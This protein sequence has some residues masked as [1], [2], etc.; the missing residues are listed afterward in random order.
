MTGAGEPCRASRS[1]SARISR[2]RRDARVDQPALGEMRRPELRRDPQ[3]LQR[4]LPVA[5][6]IRRQ[7]QK[8]ARPGLRPVPTWSMRLAEAGRQAGRIGGR[9]GNDQLLVRQLRRGAHQRARPA[10]APASS[11]RAAAPSPERRPAA[12]A[13]PDRRGALRPR[14][15]RRAC[16]S[17]A[18]AAAGRAGQGNARGWRARRAA[19]A[20]RA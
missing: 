14:R 3:E 10:R 7:M 18:A 9:G 8:E 19:S 5:G 6:E 16:G 20:D 1:A 15:C 12:P 2:S 4:D 13:H 11:G 17:S